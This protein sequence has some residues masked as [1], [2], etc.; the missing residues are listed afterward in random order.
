M[1]ANDLMLGNLF[2]GKGHNF[3]MT[4]AVS[5]CYLVDELQML[6]H[7]GTAYLIIE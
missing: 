7:K 3:L 1:A 4:G 5:L 2:F 6:Q